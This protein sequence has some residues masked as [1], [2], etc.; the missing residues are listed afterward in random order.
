MTAWGGQ[1]AV[2]FDRIRLL[3][4]PLQGGI[5]ERDPHLLARGPDAP[6]RGSGGVI[7]VDNSP[8]L[9]SGSCWIRTSDRR[10][11]SPTRLRVIRPC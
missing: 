5:R 8:E 1:I 11:M 4:F 10:I 7:T 9:S 3:A 6:G 2:Q